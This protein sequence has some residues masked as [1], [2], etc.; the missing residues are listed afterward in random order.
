MS[1]CYW[2]AFLATY[3]Y[4]AC[5]WPGTVLSHVFAAAFFLWLIGFLYLSILLSGCV[6]FRQTFTSILFT[7]GI[8]AIISLIGMI[9]PLEKYNPF[10]L[11]SKNVELISGAASMSEFFMPS[12]IS[13]AVT[14][15]G[16]WSA[17]ILF[18]RKQL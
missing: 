3:C 4:T 6:M 5:L 17:V 7:G 15:I 11:T 12:I 16:L 1:V 10:L 18:D 14:I 8:A 13:V 2:A 9:E